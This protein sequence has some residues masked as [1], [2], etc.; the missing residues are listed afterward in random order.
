MAIWLFVE[1]LLQVSERNASGV[2]P[3]R[4]WLVAGTD[5]DSTHLYIHCLSRDTSRER[6]DSTNGR[7][8]NGT[9]RLRNIGVNVINTRIDFLNPSV[10]QA[11]Q[12]PYIATQHKGAKGNPFCPHK[13]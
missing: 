12:L 5:K 9:N 13:S 3:R 4:S 7:I 10:S 6:R 8:A 2:E 1:P 11:R